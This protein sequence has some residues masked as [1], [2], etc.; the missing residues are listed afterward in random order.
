[1][2]DSHVLKFLRKRFGDKYQFAPPHR[3]EC[4]PHEGDCLIREVTHRHIVKVK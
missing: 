4:V 1:M 2:K 3:C